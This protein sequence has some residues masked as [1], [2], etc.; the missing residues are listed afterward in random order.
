M[1]RGGSSNRKEM[2]KKKTWSIRKEERRIERAEIWGYIINY[3]LE[4][5]V[6]FD[7]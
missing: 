1:A 3:P 6:I 2:I 7:D 5:Y 4:I